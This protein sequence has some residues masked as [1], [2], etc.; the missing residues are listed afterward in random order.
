MGSE[1]TIRRTKRNA[2]AEKAHRQ[3]EERLRL[4]R[5]REERQKYWAQHRKQ[6]LIGLGLLV[7]VALLS[8]QAVDYFYAPEGSLRVFHGALIGARENWVVAN[9]GTADAPRYYQIAAFDAPAGYTLD[10]GYSVAEDLSQSLYYNADDSSR[11]VQNLFLSGAGTAT[12]AE[13]MSR[14]ASMNYYQT[15]TDP[16]DTELCGM[17]VCYAYGV[18]PK[19][20]GATT[21]KATLLAYVDTPRGITLVVMLTTGDAA[22][23]ALPGEAPLTAELETLLPLITLEPDTGV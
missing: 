8:W 9:T 19:E 12:A 23:A 1:K 13:Q 22:L 16:V 18:R 4:A 2:A 20:D 7:V 3:R 5:K 21:G 6:A 10:A 14:I 11:P 17:H 15:L